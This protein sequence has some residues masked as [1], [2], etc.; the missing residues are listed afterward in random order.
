MWI[1]IILFF[2][3]LYGFNSFEEGSRASLNM[4]RLIDFDF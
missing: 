1:I 3:I 2:I 4:S